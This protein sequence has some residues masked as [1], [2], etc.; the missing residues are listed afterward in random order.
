MYEILVGAEFGE[1]LVVAFGDTD[2]QRKQCW[3]CVCRACRR[4]TG[5]PTLE[6]LE[7]QHIPLKRV[8]A[9]HLRSGRV[10]SC[11]CVHNGWVESDK[12]GNP[13]ECGAN[14]SEPP[15]PESIDN[16]EVILAS[17]NPAKCQLKGE[18][19]SNRKCI[20]GYV[21]QTDEDLSRGDGLAT[22]CQFC[23]D[24]LSIPANTRSTDPARWNKTLKNE[25]LSLARGKAVDGK[26]LIYSG[27]TGDLEEIAAHANENQGLAGRKTPG[28]ANHRPSAVKTTV[29]GHKKTDWDYSSGTDPV[30]SLSD[31]ADSERREEDIPRDIEHKRV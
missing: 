30:A 24:Q 9:E 3:L 15:H 14:A 23:R 19:Y 11:G 21:Y 18:G 31:D 26:N 17:W 10:K 22:N 25:G 28:G 12:S 7:A 1:L 5:P 16:P 6:N 29:W 2:A 4:F 8:R 13:R 20:H 27:D